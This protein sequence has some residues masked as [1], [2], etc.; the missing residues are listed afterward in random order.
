MRTQAVAHA[1]KLEQYF[2]SSRELGGVNSS[3][4]LVG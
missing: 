2:V 4:P 1:K 3:K